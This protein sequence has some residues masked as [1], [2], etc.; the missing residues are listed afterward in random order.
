MKLEIT[1][2][3]CGTRNTRSRVAR[4]TRLKCTSC[5]A[6]CKWDYEDGWAWYPSVVDNVAVLKARRVGV[7]VTPRFLVK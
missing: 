1:C 2:P 7:T 3:Y 6:E 5:G 4:Q